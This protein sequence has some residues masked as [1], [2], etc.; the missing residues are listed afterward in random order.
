M[1]NEQKIHELIH[2]LVN[3]LTALNEVKTIRMELASTK[4]RGN[5]ILETYQKLLTEYKELTKVNSNLVSRCTELQHQLESSK[6][7]IDTTEATEA[8]E[9]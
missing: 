7:A 2:I 3:E 5:Q 8:T 6:N 1:S 9:Q 4:K